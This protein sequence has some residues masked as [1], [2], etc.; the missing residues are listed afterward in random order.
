M[1]ASEDIVI[2]SDRPGCITAYALLLWL[3]GAGLL[4]IAFS[5]PSDP[6]LGPEAAIAPAF[7]ALVLIA[8]GIGLWQMSVWSWW[9]VVIIQSFGVLGA[10]FSLIGGDILNAIVSGTVSGGILYWFITNRHLFLTGTAY[11]TSVSSDGE[12]VVEQVSVSRSNVSTAVIV[13]VILVICVA[14]VVIIAILTL[15][16]PQIG[17]VFSGIVDGLS[18]P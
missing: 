14:P 16:G 2:K 15:L 1:S 4:F 6:F 9:L 7:F 13:G 17:D 11:R 12:S 18:A 8:T 3:G 10:L 5:A